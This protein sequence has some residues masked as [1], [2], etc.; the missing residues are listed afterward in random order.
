MQCPNCQMDLQDNSTFCIHCGSRFNNQPQSVEQS[1]QQSNQSFVK[2][3]KCGATNSSGSQFCMN[4]G[5]KIEIK[6][7]SNDTG[8]S[9]FKLGLSIFNLIVVAPAVL[10][11][12][13]FW[14]ILGALGNDKTLYYGILSVGA[15]YGIGSLIFLIYSIFCMINSAIS[16]NKKFNRIIK[17]IV[18][19][20]FCLFMLYIIVLMIDIIRPRM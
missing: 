19:G 18:I 8:E 14:T 3:S 4:C 2:C 17:I 13:V 12:M 15:I 10:S 7:D 20:V 1:M 6:K 16:D 9:V 11:F 5:E